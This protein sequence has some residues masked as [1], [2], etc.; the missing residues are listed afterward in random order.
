MIMNQH[1]FLCVFAIRSKIGN[2]VLVSFSE[3]AEV[4]SNIEHIIVCT[5]LEQVRVSTT[6]VVERDAIRVRNGEQSRT[7]KTPVAFSVAPRNRV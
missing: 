7:R 4:V 1:D 3:L 6:L 5:V 2:S